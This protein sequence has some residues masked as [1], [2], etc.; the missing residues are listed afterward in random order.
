MP[1]VWLVGDY[2]IVLTV[3]HSH[4]GCESSNNQERSRADTRTDSSRFDVI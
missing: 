2:K 1:L 4:D 3:S